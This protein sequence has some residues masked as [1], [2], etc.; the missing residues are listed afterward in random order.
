MDYKCP[1]NWNRFTTSFVTI[2]GEKLL[3]STMIENAHSVYLFPGL[4]LLTSASS[5]RRS[6]SSNFSS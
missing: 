6:K 1:S 2:A 4:R 5:N 3:Y